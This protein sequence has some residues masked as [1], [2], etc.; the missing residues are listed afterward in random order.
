MTFPLRIAPLL[1]ASPPTPRRLSVAIFQLRDDAI[2][3]R[4]GRTV[5]PK[6]DIERLVHCV[7]LK[8]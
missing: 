1:T 8:F 4:R 2:L 5:A 3:N 7:A 6:G